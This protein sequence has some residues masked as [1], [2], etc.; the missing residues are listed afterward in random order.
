MPWP[1]SARG[2]GFGSLSHIQIRI[3]ATASTPD[4]SATAVALTVSSMKK[5]AVNTAAR[6]GVHP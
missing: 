1:I 5:P 2:S 4:S 6:I 3:A